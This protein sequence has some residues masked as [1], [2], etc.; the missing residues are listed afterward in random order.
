MGE[1]KTDSNGLESFYYSD[2]GYVVPVKPKTRTI[3]NAELRKHETIPDYSLE[4]FEEA[5]NNFKL[6]TKC[7]EKDF[8]GEFIIS[9]TSELNRIAMV[10]PRAISES[11]NNVWQGWDK[12]LFTIS[13]QSGMVFNFP[14]TKAE[15]VF[16]TEINDD[17]MYFRGG[18]NKGFTVDYALDCFAKLRDAVKPL[19]DAHDVSMSD[20]DFA[21]LMTAFRMN[22]AGLIMHEV[23]GWVEYIVAGKGVEDIHFGFNRRFFARKGINYVPVGQVSEYKG[24]PL[25]W[26]ERILSVEI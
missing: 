12:S 15:T 7:L 4:Q 25:E 9:Q 1:I 26:V 19:F 5:E 6:L 16:K 13:L 22:T 23:P 11:S 17:D 8:G 2:S 14:I 20:K 24:L 18:G 10:T 3:Y 21:L